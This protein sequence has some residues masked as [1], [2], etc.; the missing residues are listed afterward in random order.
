MEKKSS[1]LFLSLAILAALTPGCQK[2]LEL[3]QDKEIANT[4][5]PGQ[6]INC[7][8]ESIWVN[9]GDY[10]QEFR[11]VLYD[12][13]ENPVAITT[14]AIGT[15][16]PYVTFKYDSWHRLRE[17]RG[18]YIGGVY[19]FLHFYGFD[20]HGRIG[21]DTAYFFGDRTIIT[22]VYDNQNRITTTILGNEH[23]DIKWEVNY[24]YDA[25]GNL[26]NRSDLAS[27]YDNKVNLYRTN[28]IWMFLARDYSMNNPFIADAYNA[29]GFPTVIKPGNPGYFTFLNLNIPLIN[30]QISF[31]CR[32]AYW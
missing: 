9:P 13:Y 22:I 29:S 26:M 16:H 7:R 18:E 4:P 1:F 21:V 27:N 10:F 30:S 32:Q 2:N 17:Y 20:Q 25:A 14:P 31:G 8:I 5:L 23:N 28:D 3:S 15:G 19:E 12:E 6:A 11:L 24:T